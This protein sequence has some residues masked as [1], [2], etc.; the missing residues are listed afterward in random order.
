[1]EQGRSAKGVLRVVIAARVLQAAA[2]HASEAS[3]IDGDGVEHLAALTHPDAVAAGNACD[4]D[5]AFGV[6]ADPVG[7]HPAPAL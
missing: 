5:G 2:E 1:V 4:P 6:R 7:R 3:A